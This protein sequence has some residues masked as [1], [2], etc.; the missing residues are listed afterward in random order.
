MKAVSP[1]RRLICG[2]LPA[3]AASQGAARIEAVEDLLHDSWHTTEVIIFE[4]T[5]AAGQAG[6]EDLLHRRERTYP[7]NL[8]SLVGDEPWPVDDLHPD[9]RASP[10]QPLP[11]PTAPETAQEAATDALPGSPKQEEVVRMDE[12]QPGTDAAADVTSPSP[13]TA[14]P[15][16]EPRLEPH[17]LLRLL[18]AAAE[19]E[20]SLRRQSYRLPGS[21]QLELSA[22]ARRIRNAAHLALLWHARWTQ[23]TPR[24][25][26]GQPLL[27]QLGPRVGDLHQLE[28][29][30]EVTKSTILHFRAQLWRQVPEASGHISLNQSRAVRSGE[31]HYLDHPK[32]GILVRIRPVVPPEELQ[33][34][35][36]AWRAEAGYDT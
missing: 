11:K 18:N 19:F 31:L 6:A 36:L 3:L 13:A 22:Q 20:A 1:V 4:R 34:A 25:A 28:G 12:L 16:I 21:E 9:T 5:A 7:A 17:P 23:P 32:L 8:R 2:L 15:P 30:L 27:L 26:A 35:L 10:E 24:P 29:F 14:P 33:E